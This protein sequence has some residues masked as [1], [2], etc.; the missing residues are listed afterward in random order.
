LKCKKSIF[1][2]CLPELFLSYPI[3]EVWDYTKAC[4]KLYVKDSN[5]ALEDIEKKFFGG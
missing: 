3:K 1:F 5:I 2:S 4:K